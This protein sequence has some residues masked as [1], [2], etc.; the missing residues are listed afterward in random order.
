[1]T[2]ELWW[3]DGMPENWG[4][5]EP[6]D[7][8]EMAKNKREEALNSKIRKIRRQ[9][10]KD[11]EKVIHEDRKERGVHLFKRRIKPGIIAGEEAEVEFRTFEDLVKTEE[12]IGSNIHDPHVERNSS[13]GPLF[14]SCKRSRFLLG[15]IYH[16]SDD[17]GIHIHG[18][19]DNIKESEQ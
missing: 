8:Y 9:A 5:W 11:I 7:M 15:F 3:E 2:K 19:E 13:G 16:T 6:V 12:W 10:E 4:N 17:I 1:M 18:S 14:V